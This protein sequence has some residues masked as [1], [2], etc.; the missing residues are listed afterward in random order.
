MPDTAPPSDEFEPASVL[1]V[2]DSRISA[3]KLAKAMRALGHRTQIAAD[4]VEAMQRLR[5][6][7]FDIILLDI[8]MP[9]MD[10][11]AVLNLLK[12]DKSLRDLPVIVIS[13]LDDEIGSVAKAIKLGAEDFLPKSFEL[14]ILKARLNASL[15]RKRFRD[16]ELDYFHDLEQLT[17]AAEVIEAGAFHPAELEIDRV[18][19]REDPLGRLAVVFR[20]LAHEIY[21]RER[22][23]DRTVRTLRGTLIVLAAGGIFGITP[24]LGRMAA[25]LGTPPLGFVL[26]ANTVAAIIC[27]AIAATRSGWPRLRLAHLRFFAAWA[28]IL[29]CLYQLLTVVISKHVEASVIALVGSSRGF[30]V[31][32]LAALMSIERPSLRRF[33]GLGVGFAAVAAVLMNRGAGG[34][35]SDL[36]WLIA[37]LVLPLLLAIHTLLMTWRPSDLDAFAA[38][39]IMMAVSA[40]L[41]APVAYASGDVFWPWDSIGRLQLIILAL[42][43]ASAIA[44][45]LA[46]DLVRTAGAVFASQMAYSQT[47]AGI[48]WGMLLL[49]EQL[50][51]AAWGALALVILGFWLVEPR[52]AGAEFKAT[53]PFSRA[54]KA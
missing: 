19:D 37:A 8:V 16:R 3:L 4:G 46:L 18:A 49:D 52:R 9:R 33:A 27:F 14:S 36:L 11:Y 20:G 10:G 13:S 12:A 15:A 42:G 47:L 34:E 1:I 7:R 38:V 40:I 23:L 50:T 45:A 29:G 6:G 39:G 53:V 30:M 44:L 54:P 26:W 25:V 48:A 5:D 24:A 17:R 43:A 41:I 32:G 35:E 2:D 28:V 51:P 21:D 22:R 31:F